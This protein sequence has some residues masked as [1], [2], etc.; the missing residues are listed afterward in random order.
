M[1]G[2]CEYAGGPG[3]NAWCRSSAHLQR[4]PPTPGQPTKVPVLIPLRLGLLGPDG[5]ELPLRLRGRCACLLLGWG[6]GVG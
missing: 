5:R 1:L 4:T 3:H 6:Y 2:V